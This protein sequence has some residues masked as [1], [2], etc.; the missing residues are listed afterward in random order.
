[1]YNGYPIT[2]IIDTGSQLN[3]MREMIVHRIRVP[4]D[5]TQSITMNDA[6]GG[7]SVFKGHVKSINFN[8]GPLD[9][10][11]EIWI[12]ENVPF[13]L[14][15]GQLWQTKNH[16]SIVEKQTGTHLEFCNKDNDEIQYDVCVSPTEK[17]PSAEKEPHPRKPL[18]YHQPGPQ[19]YA[20]TTP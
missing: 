8:C 3:V 12:G 18:F 7:E 10:P 2:A 20:L 11:C 13:D 5:F 1:M 4:I 15:L 17:E 14:L 19:T 6:N 16:V 9:T